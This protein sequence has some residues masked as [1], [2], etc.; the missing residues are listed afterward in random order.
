MFFEHK[1]LA[2][3]TII[4]SIFTLGFI[5]IKLFSDKHPAIMKKIIT[6]TTIGSITLCLLGIILML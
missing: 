1:L 5:G 4:L 6:G 3:I 2:F